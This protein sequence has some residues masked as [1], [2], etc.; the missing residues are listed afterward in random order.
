MGYVV[1]GRADSSIYQG[2]SELILQGCNLSCLG[3]NDMLTLAKD[4]LS[5]ST[6]ASVEHEEV[7]LTGGDDKGRQGNLPQKLQ[8]PGEFVVPCEIGGQLVEK[9]IYDSGASMN[10]IPSSLYEKHGLT[11]IK[12]TELSLP[13]ADK[14]VKVPLGIVEDVELKIDKLKLPADFVVFDMENSQNVRI[15]LGRP[16][17]ATAVTV[18]DLKQEKLTMEVE[19]QRVEIKA[20]KRSHDPP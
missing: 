8:D 3:F 18:I 17:L 14:S 2:D 10:I 11:K 9:T 15:I 7:A 16:F 12:P 4:G 5:T 20:L 19:G 13:L 6:K 1:L